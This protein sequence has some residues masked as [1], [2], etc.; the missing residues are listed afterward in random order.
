MTNKNLKTNNRVDL[1]VYQNS[2]NTHINYRKLYLL[3]VF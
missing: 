1:A 2:D 3:C